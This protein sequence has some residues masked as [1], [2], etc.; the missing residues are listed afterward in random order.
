MGGGGGAG[1]SVDRL[2]VL[3]CNGIEDTVLPP[4]VIGGFLDG[5]VFKYVLGGAW[6]DTTDFTAYVCV[7]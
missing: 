2:T 1:P 3:L 7:G 6:V 5:P 4:Y